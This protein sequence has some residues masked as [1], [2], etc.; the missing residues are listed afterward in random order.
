[1]IVETIA[2]IEA[3]LLANLKSK[4][5]FSTSNM[6][7]SAVALWSNIQSTIATE[8]SLLQN[9]M[10][11][12]ESEVEAIIGKVTTPTDAWWQKQILLWQ[13]SSTNPQ[14]IQ[15]DTTNFFPYYA[16]VNAAYRLI[17]NCSVVTT[18]N[19]IIQIKVTN[20]GAI[21]TA[22]ETTALTAYINSIAPAGIQWTIVN[23]LPDRLYVNA[24]IYYNGQ[25][26]PVISSTV[27][28]ALDSYLKNIPF[29]GI[30]KISE[31][32]DT[33]QAVPGVTDVVIN[34]VAARRNITP[35]ANKTTFTRFYSTYSGQIIQEDTGGQTFANTL[36]FIIG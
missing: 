8:F 12:F 26:A 18:G 30:V 15:L 7:P 10:N 31:I 4:P 24:Q 36:T 2:Q 34:S 17:S 21:L 27:I 11:I 22:P 19:N 35:F 29:D 3:R 5:P 14:V 23:E 16:V 9:L 6:S 32:E 1:M 13:Y 33:I 20:N 28:S 25:Y